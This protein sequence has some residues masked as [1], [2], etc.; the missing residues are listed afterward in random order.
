MREYGSVCERA[1][2]AVIEGGFT[3]ALRRVVVQVLI[4]RDSHCGCAR[5]LRR[6]CVE[7]RCVSLSL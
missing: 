2:Q 3:A 7:W 1:A 5:E 6:Q 4:E